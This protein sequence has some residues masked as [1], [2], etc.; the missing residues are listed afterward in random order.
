MFS[1]NFVYNHNMSRFGKT[2]NTSTPSLLLR[3]EQWGMLWFLGAPGIIHVTI[4]A[5]IYR[6]RFQIKTECNCAWKFS[7]FWLLLKHVSGVCVCRHLTYRRFMRWI[8]EC[9]G[10]QNSRVFLSCVAT[11]IRNAFPSQQNCGVKYQRQRPW[12]SNVHIFS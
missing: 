2:K 9:L 12:Y 8:W 10:K 11:Q 3:N 6:F 4:K 5:C 1:V 7:Q